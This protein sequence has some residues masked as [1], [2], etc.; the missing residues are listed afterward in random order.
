MAVVEVAWI[1]VDAGKLAHHATAVDA[2]GTV[3][4][5]RRVANEQAAIEQMIAQA[6]RGTAEARWAVDLTS[7]GAALLLALLVAA[8]QK[9]IYVPGSVVN[10][11]A[12]GFRGEGKT[13]A[14]DAKVIAETARLRRDLTE[15]STP[16]ELVVELSLLVGHRADLMADWVRGVN[17]LRDLLTRV[18]PALER[19]LDY[20]TRSALILVAGYCTPAAIRTAGE[21]RLTDWLH[22][23]G[24][25][26]P[27]TP[28]I[29]AK[30]LAAAATQTVTLPG[31]ATIARL[32]SQLARRLLDLDRQIK[33]LDKLITERFRTHPQAKIIESLP[34]MGPILGAEFIAITAADLA[35]FGSPARMATYAGLAPVPNDSGRRTGI[36]HRPRR[37]HRRLRHVFYMAAFS[38]LKSNGPSRTFYQRKRAERQRHNKAIIALARRLVDVLWA[39]LRDNRVFTPTAPPTAAAKA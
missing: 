23:Q 17:R 4:W 20:S 39:L 2:E 30:A 27:S 22:T 36:L 7:A 10:R 6:R 26:R 18:C 33:D 5:S 35:A 8:G 31:E 14:K 15:L 37:Y 16:D 38:S 11:M 3:L 25:H 24:A 21:Q 9:V 29:V 19:A 12:G 28:S 1:G 34:G 13:D 32:I